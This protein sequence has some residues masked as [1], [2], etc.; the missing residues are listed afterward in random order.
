[1]YGCLEADTDHC[2]FIHDEVDSYYCDQGYELTNAKQCGNT[3]I[4]GGNVEE[5]IKE[6]KYL[7]N[8]QNGK[9]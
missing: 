2:G 9:F 5:D 1:M 3:A 7:G 4:L 6:K 8:L